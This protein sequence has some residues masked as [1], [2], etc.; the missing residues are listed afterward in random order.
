M[1]KGK[2]SGKIGVSILIHG[3]MV[4]VIGLIALYQLYN[5]DSTN[6]RNVNTY[7]WIIGVLTFLFMGVTVF[8]GLYFIRQVVGPIAHSVGGVAGIIQQV[9]SGSDQVFASAQQLAEGSSAQA[10]SLEE[11][12][13]SLEE[14]SSMTKQNADNASQAR[15]MM[16]EAGHSWRR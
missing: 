5:V 12:S 1:A 16:Q 7:M 14:L 3:G 15:A 6:V 2:I 11:T 4:A 9:S 8:L 13:S 10:S